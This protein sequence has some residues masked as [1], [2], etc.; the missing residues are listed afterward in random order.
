LLFGRRNKSGP[1]GL[2][3]AARHHRREKE[4]IM[5]MASLTI[6]ALLAFPSMAYANVAHN[7]DLPAATISARAIHPGQALPSS[8]TPGRI[9]RSAAACAP[10]SATPVWDRNSA[11][12]GYSCVPAFANGA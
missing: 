3:F 2:S 1:A 4:T 6:A 11:L 5:N 7:G 8:A 9:V 10:D 12:L